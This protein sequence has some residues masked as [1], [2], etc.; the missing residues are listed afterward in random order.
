MRLA[1]IFLGTLSLI[2]AAAG[3]VLPLLPTVP[4]VLLA[5]FFF[6]RGHPPL[7]AWLV[8]HPRFG[9]HIVAWRSRGAISRRGKR[10]ALLAFAISAATGLVFA[11]LPWSLVPLAAAAIGGSWIWTRPEA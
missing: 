11:P 7:E 9:P 5:A 8:R 6:A 10:A 3:A 4:F 2:L 1:Y